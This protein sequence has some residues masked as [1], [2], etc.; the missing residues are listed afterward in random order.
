MIVP[1]TTPALAQTRCS[2]SR[3]QN[4]KP[5]VKRPQRIKPA[6]CPENVNESFL[7][8]VLGI[9]TMEQNSE[10]VCDGTFL[11]TLDKM[12]ESFPLTVLTSFECLG[13]IHPPPHIIGIRLVT[14]L[15]KLF[16]E[17]A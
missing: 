12:P 1:S 8:R 4:V 13:I 3:E 16:V 9:T 15:F 7:N 2:V 10:S 14:E 17:L 5:L 11:I 6:D